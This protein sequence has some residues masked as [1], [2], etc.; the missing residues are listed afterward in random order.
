METS[1]RPGSDSAAHGG[2]LELGAVGFGKAPVF[3]DPSLKDRRDMVTGANDDGFHL[4][5][6]DVAR[7]PDEML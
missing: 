2:R 6:V 7:E 5:G 3:V 1:V 4:K